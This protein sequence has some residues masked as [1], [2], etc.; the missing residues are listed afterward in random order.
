MNFNNLLLS[1]LDDF[2]NREKIFILI[3]LLINLDYK[4]ELK[5]SNLMLN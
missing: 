1:N 3:F 5:I 4:I 2:L